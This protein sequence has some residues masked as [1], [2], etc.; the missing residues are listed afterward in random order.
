M[1][2]LTQLKSKKLSRRG[3][4]KQSERGSRRFM[5]PTFL[6]GNFC[7]GYSLTRSLDLDI[8]SGHFE[9]EDQCLISSF[10]LFL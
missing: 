4:N 8:C 9:F 6:S 7:I 10:Q 3:E 1:E 2:I 5:M